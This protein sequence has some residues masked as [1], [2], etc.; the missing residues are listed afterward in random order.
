MF[1]LNSLLLFVTR[2]ITCTK[3]Y[4]LNLKDK[5][6]AKSRISYTAHNVLENTGP[7]IFLDNSLTPENIISAL[8]ETQNLD[9]RIIRK[10][11]IIQ[12]SLENGD[13][14]H[15][16]SGVFIHASDT[17]LV[18]IKASNITNNHVMCIRI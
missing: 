15:Q 9:F 4:I 5:I 18:M 16:V 12:R 13:F 8:N 17:G 7:T 6:S 10:I 11:K 14:L 3:E 2:I 1:S